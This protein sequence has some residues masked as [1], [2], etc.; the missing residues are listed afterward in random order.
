MG[1][2][3]FLLTC[4][5][6]TAQPAAGRPL[7]LGPAAAHSR[8]RAG[9]SRHVHRGGQ[10]RRHRVSADS[11]AWKTAS[12]S[13]TPCPTPPRL[14]FFDGLEGPVGETGQCSRDNLRAAPSGADEGGATAGWRPSRRAALAPPTDGPPIVQRGVV[15]DEDIRFLDG[16]DTPV[17]DGGV[18]SIVPAVAGELIPPGR[19][20]P[21]LTA[22]VGDVR[23]GTP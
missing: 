9:L 6:A 8:A 11:I 15:A 16:L 7:P 20:T 22:T 1:I 10:Q 19:G 21:G 5:L 2:D 13:S 3:P 17:G 23:L 4:A 12:S 18:V 14:A